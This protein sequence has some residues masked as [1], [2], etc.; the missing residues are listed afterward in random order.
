MTF[1]MIHKVPVHQVHQVPEMPNARADVENCSFQRTIV[2]DL[3]SKEV[4]YSAQRFFIFSKFI[5]LF[6]ILGRAVD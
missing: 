5:Y 6:F 3:I 2:Y 1:V 4:S